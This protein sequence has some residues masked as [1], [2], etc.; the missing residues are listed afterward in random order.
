M[1]K[2]FLILACVVDS[3]CAAPSLYLSAKVGMGRVQPIDYT[4]DGTF[5]GET[6]N[7]SGYLDFKYYNR[8]AKESDVPF[9][10]IALGTDLVRL[11]LQ[12]VRFETEY[13]FRNKYTLSPYTEGVIVNGIIVENHNEHILS[14]QSQDVG[15]KIFDIDIKNQI[16]MFNTYYDFK[17]NSK[18]T[19][20]I[21]AGLGISRTK[22]RAFHF[23]NLGEDGRAIIEDKSTNF[24]WAVGA[25]INYAVN[26]Q[27]SLDFNYRYV[28]LGDIN[29]EK[30]YS[31]SN[32]TYYQQF[33]INNSLELKSHDFSI[34]LRYK[35]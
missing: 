18:F 32:N 5:L 12:N 11:N 10:T 24:A 13:S 30:K 23:M 17:T 28:D 21:N 14:E 16:L 3:A 8:E 6:S 34:G 29:G 9:V 31:F 2:S 22:L 27:A 4:L 15:D 7:V 19:P 20:Y 35:F 1:K 26:D 25:G 33:K